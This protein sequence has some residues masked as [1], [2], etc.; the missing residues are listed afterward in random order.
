[1]QSTLKRSSSSIVLP[2]TSHTE[3]LT[4]LLR[5]AGS[6]EVSA[7]SLKAGNFEVP[8]HR[9]NL[10]VKVPN[11]DS[12][13]LHHFFHDVN[14]ALQTK[15]EGRYVVVFTAQNSCENSASTAEEM[16][17]TSRR[18]LL[19]TDSADPITPGAFQLKAFIECDFDWQ[20]YDELEQVC[21]R[22]VWITPNILAGLVIGLIMC[23][24]LSIGICCINDV[25]T[26][27]VFLNK[28]DPGPAKGK[29]F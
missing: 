9:Q 29:E 16:V 6:V 21:F 20:W 4:G 2:F 10:F 12:N 11:V 8:A 15:T 5:E 22:Y 27:T 28:D 14:A 7:D 1:M 23:I 26:P 19:S 18:R 25:Q 24:T 17:Q 13:K 3:S